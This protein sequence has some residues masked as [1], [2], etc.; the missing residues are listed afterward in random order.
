MTI[1]TAQAAHLLGLHPR[2]IPILKEANLL[3]PLGKQRAGVPPRYRLDDV[4]RLAN[5]DAK[6]D[7]TTNII[8]QSTQPRS[9][10]HKHKPNPMSPAGRFLLNDCFWH[11]VDRNIPAEQTPLMTGV[12]NRQPLATVLQSRF[13]LSPNQADLEIRAA[14]DEVQL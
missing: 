10:R 3:R 9:R 7:A 4:R 8:Y 12:Y 13:G 1:T 6:F 2:D 14:R 11:H 5:D